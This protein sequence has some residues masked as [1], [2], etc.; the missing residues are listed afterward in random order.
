MRVAYRWPAG[1]QLAGKANL[2]KSVLG[3]KLANSTGA[4]LQKTVTQYNTLNQ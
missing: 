1:L 2:R 3:E 4:V